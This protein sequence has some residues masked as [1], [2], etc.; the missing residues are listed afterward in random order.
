[1]DVIAWIDDRV[2]FL[3]QTRLPQEERYVVTEDYKVVANAIRNLAVRGAPL[4]GIA[5]AYGAALA[6]R[7]ISEDDSL[8]FVERFSLAAA[9]LESTRPTAVNLSWALQRIRRVVADTEGERLADRV[10]SVLREA[11]AIHDEDRGMCESI[12]DHGVSL[13]REGSCV[14]THCNTGAL[15]TGGRGTALGIVHRAWELGKV[16]H[17]YIDETR[18]LMQGSRLTAWELK[19]L[20]IPHTLIT[21]GTAAFMMQQGRIDGIMVGADRIAPNGDIA[22]KIGTYGL[23]VIANAHHVPFFVAAPGSTID[24]GI[25]MGSEIPVE[26]R[27]DEEITQMG[28]QRIAPEGTSTYAP[29]FDI[30]PNGL[31]SAIITDRGICRAPYVESLR[32]HRSRAVDG[33]D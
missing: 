6:V 31:I 22:N 2:R 3:D 19:K 32:I 12:A 33:H 17:V 20:G 25:K 7:K 16:E 15:A 11:R 5:A 28:E 27:R 24:W 1:M 26:V 23:A 21:D 10:E 14:L 13:L 4:I 8:Q 9:E 30:T 18:P 29:A